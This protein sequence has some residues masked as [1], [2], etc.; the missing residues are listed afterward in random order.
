MDKL[1]ITVAVDSSVSYPGNPN[2]PEHD[3]MK[4]VSRQYIDA[5]NAGASITHLHGV[6][7]LDKEFGPDGRKSVRI[8]FDGWQDLTERIRSEVD[9]VIQYGIAVA[10]LEDKI[11]LMDFQPEMMSYAFAAQDMCFQPDPEY[12]PNEMYALHPR[13]E[14]VEFAKAAKSKG[15]KPELE[16]F[17]TGPFWNA[18]HVR[19]EG[20]LDDPLWATLLIGWPG[21]TWTPPT[22]DALMYLVNHLPRPASWNLSVMD[23]VQQWRLVPLAIA[24]GGHIRV[25][26]EDNPYLPNGELSTSNAQLVENV[27]KMAECMGREIASPDDARRIV[28]TSGVPAA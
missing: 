24:L 27:V 12:S 6:R 22:P 21:G 7:Y 8:D 5:V 20:V 23:P 15:V 1:I 25:G 16:C 2:M 19:K 14:L 13:P 17:Y 3:D 9:A 4:S 10:R 26:W 28:G 18:E 11:K